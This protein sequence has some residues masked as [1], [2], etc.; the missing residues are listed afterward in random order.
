MF[1]KGIA[2]TICAL[3]LLALSA[4][5]SMLPSAKTTTKAPWSTFEDVNSAYNQIVPGKTTIN[6]LEKM[7][8]DPKKMANIEIL[9]IKDI[10]NIYLPNSSITIE[11]LDKG[12]QQCLEARGECFAYSIN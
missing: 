9:T 6:D 4:C 12:M 10:V 1:T 2:L 8:L 11:D 3:M 7:G 5:S